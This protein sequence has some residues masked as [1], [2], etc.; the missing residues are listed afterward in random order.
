MIGRKGLEARVKRLGEL[1]CGL[2]KELT[3]WDEMLWK[4]EPLPLPAAERQEYLAAIRR[5]SRALGEAQ[6]VLSRAVRR[7]PEKR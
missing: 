3:I 6:L 5:A 7:R 4:K 1:A 2:A